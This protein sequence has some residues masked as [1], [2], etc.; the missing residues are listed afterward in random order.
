ML[1]RGSP[2]ETG[3]FSSAPSAWSRVSSATNPTLF[4]SLTPTAV[5]VLVDVV[6]VI[7]QVCG[8]ALIGVVQVKIS[9]D[10]E[11]PISS[12]AAADI[13]LGGLA[14]QCASF[15]TFITLLFV[16]IKR[17]RSIG[18]G[19][20]VLRNLRILLGLN[21]AAAMFILLRTVYRLAAECQGYFG[22]ANSSQTLFTCLEFLPVILAIAVFSV[23]PISKFFP[24]EEDLATGQ[25]VMKESSNASSNPYGAYP[26]SNQS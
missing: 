1:P 22:T 6:T 24:S 23:V 4:A 3:C 5:F 15:L 8:A 13:L 16:A 2:V 18:L 14:V 7:V 11:P 10:E 25:F 17:T 19:H 9:R 26:Y 20:P 21:L 12:K